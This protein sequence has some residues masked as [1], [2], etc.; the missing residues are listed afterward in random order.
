MPL[1]KKVQLSQSRVSRFALYADT[2][3]NK[4]S[5]AFAILFGLSTLVH[6]IQLCRVGRRAWVFVPVVIGAFMETA[7]WAIRVRQSD[8]DE[9]MGNGHIAPTLISITPAICLLILVSNT[10]GYAHRAVA[11][12]LRILLTLFHLLFILL[13]QFVGTI[14]A[15]AYGWELPNW[16]SADRN[17]AWTT[18]ASMVVLSVV[19]LVE[20]AI[21]VHLVVYSRRNS[22][23]ERSESSVGMRLFV[24]IAIVWILLLIRNIYRSIQLKDGFQFSVQFNSMLFDFLEGLT[25]LLSLIVM[26]VFHPARLL[27][28][29]LRNQ[30]VGTENIQMLNEPTVARE[31][32]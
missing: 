14:Q 18:V 21:G 32:Q 25:M 6:F 20:F 5:Y 13:M 22:A 12:P 23:V 26:N 24:T 30:P 10:A 28:P 29:P 2:P 3:S 19:I 16:E 9:N 4:S 17:G 1:H 11:R 27:P 31:A 8:M 15:M 7:G